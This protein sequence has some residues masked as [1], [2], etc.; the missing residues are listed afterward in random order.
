MNNLRWILAA[1]AIAAP[2]VQTTAWAAGR[3]AKSKG[4]DDAKA[5]SD[6]FQRICKAY[7]DGAW[8]DLEKDLQPGK[9]PPGLATEQR[10]ELEAI[11]KA[12]AECRPAWWQSCKANAKGPIH[13]VVWGRKLDLT[14]EPGELGLKMNYGAD[15][16][17]IT[18]SWVA[19]EMDSREKGGHGVTRGAGSDFYLWYTLGTA[20][21][22]TQISVQSLTNLSEKDR[23]ALGRYQCFRSGLTAFYYTTPEARR[24][25][26]YVFCSTWPKHYEK[27]DAYPRKANGAMFLAEVLTDPAKYPSLPMPKNIPADG[28]EEKLADLYC[29]WVQKHGWTVAEDIALRKAIHKFA[30]TNTDTRS[31][32][33]LQ[34]VT[35]PNDL[36]IS[37]DPAG[38]E[39]LR[40]LRDAW[41]KKQFD[42]ASR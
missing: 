39:K 40:P 8:E 13:P 9:D 16:I 22:W 7:L 15:H 33:K 27:E 32:P 35:L 30:E 36:K 28:A 34:L 1:V 25:A 41:L 23:L 37:L 26:A 38:D 12:V 5:S 11:R 19:T 17:A 20:H 42:K 14:Y 24:L 2:G 10:E 29:D 4:A 31:L 6:S 21:T 3:A 18:V